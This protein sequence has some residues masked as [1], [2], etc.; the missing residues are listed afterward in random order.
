[1]RKK[2]QEFR[3]KCWRPMGG[4]KRDPDAYYQEEDDIE[5]Y[6][7]GRGKTIDD[8]MLNA[9]ARAI[10]YMSRYGYDRF[11][12]MLTIADNEKQ[13]QELEKEWRDQNE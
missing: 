12:I 5:I 1:M 6:V 10:Q 13:F 4:A 8:R 11:S 9:K 2:S 7:S 3:V